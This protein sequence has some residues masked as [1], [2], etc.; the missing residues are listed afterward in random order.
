MIRLGQRLQ[1]ER[2]R[3]GLTLE[4]IAKATRIR[5]SFLEAIE[6][7]NYQGL[8]SSAYVQGFV[9]NYVTYLGLPVKELL[10]LFRREFN[11]QEYL[12]VLPESFTKPK[13]IR[14]NRFRLWQTVGIVGFF[15]LLFIGYIAFQYKSAF[16]NPSLF[17]NYPKEQQ[18]I[19]SQT[20]TVLGQ[21]EQNTTVL[22]NGL[23]AFVDSSGA[24]KKEITVAPG[25]VTISIKATNS[26]G[27]I[28]TIE[29]HISVKTSSS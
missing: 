8:P 27:K 14:V 12:G 10:A 19:S 5:L 23:P 20:I 17:V 2:K 7:G 22:V 9:K 6:K 29:R 15:L 13:T 3:Q 25:D 16:I 24:F 4:Q 28:S 11:E 1:E 26:F 21:T 18:A